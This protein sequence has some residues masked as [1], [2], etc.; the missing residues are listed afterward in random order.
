[1]FPDIEKH[2]WVAWCTLPPLIQLL[3]PWRPS[4]IPQP[5]WY[6]LLKFKTVIVK[7]EPTI[8]QP[9]CQH[10]NEG[11]VAIVLFN[12]SAPVAVPTFLCAV[13]FGSYCSLCILYI[14][15]VGWLTIISPCK[16]PPKCCF[17]LGIS[18]CFSRKQKRQK[19]FH[20]HCLLTAA[21]GC[22]CFCLALTFGTGVILGF[23][24]LTWFIIYSASPSSSWPLPSYTPLLP[25][26]WPLILFW[27]WTSWHSLVLAYC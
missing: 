15:Q 14:S 4:L 5:I 9:V 27:L 3:R 2:N 13:R 7:P 20:F 22:C 17:E 16:S 26:V 12:G 1:M 6:Q 25:G 24:L 10:Q 19:S 8:W 11:E 18:F 23:W 21:P